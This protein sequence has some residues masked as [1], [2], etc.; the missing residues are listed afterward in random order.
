[1][2]EIIVQ[3]QRGPVAMLRYIAAAVK[4]RYLIAILKVPFPSQLQLNLKFI[5]KI[6]IC[7]WHFFYINNKSSFIS[8]PIQTTYHLACLSLLKSA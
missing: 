8:T 6:N 7:C 3:D 4:L 1:M 2:F 5:S